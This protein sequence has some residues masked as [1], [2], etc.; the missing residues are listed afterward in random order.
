MFRGES[1]RFGFRREAASLEAIALLS[2]VDLE[3]PRVFKGGLDVAQLPSEV[4][5]GRGGL[6]QLRLELRLAL[7]K[8]GRRDCHRRRVLLFRLTPRSLD[9]GELLFDEGTRHV[10]LTNQFVEIRLTFRRS[11]RG[12]QTVL[13]C[14]LVGVPEYA[15][16]IGESTIRGCSGSWRRRRASR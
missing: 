6:R 2:M 7:R 3:T 13:G 9:V 11:L 15:F 16:D 1:A 10:F 14:T 4:I 5:A 12:R 8:R